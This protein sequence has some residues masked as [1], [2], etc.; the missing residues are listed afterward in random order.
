MLLDEWPMPDEQVDD[1]KVRS[2]IRYLDPE[3]PINRKACDTAALVAILFIAVEALC[4]LW[5][6]VR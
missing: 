1:D 3:E 2:A 5:L 4:V 6:L